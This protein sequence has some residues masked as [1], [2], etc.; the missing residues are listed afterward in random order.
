VTAA[1]QDGK[2]CP[3]CG[4]KLRRPKPA[5]RCPYTLDIFDTTEAQDAVQEQESPELVRE[6]PT[7]KGMVAVRRAPREG[8]AR[9][10]EARHED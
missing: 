5:P 7:R 4:A 6:P 3:H 8:D 2:F 9:R 1:A 10:E